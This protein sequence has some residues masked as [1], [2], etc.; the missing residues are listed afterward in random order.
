MAKILISDDLEEN[1]YLL[2]AL[3]QGHGHE[4]ISA[5]N[6]EEA[7]RMARQEMPDLIVTDILMPVMD[8]FTLCRE[9]KKDANLS[10]IPLI[11]YT[12]TYTDEENKGFGLGLGA[13]RYLIKPLEPDELIGIVNEVLEESDRAGERQA[14]KEIGNETSY[15]REYNE[16]L[17]RKLQARMAQLEVANGQLREQLSERRNAEMKLRRLYAAIQNAAECVAIGDDQGRIEYSNPAFEK[18]T[19]FSKDET[20]SLN[21][22]LMTSGIHDES[23]YRELWQAIS[24]EKSWTGHLTKKYGDGEKLELD[25]AISPIHDTSQD[26]GGFVLIMR[27][28]TV[29][30]RLR[31]QLLQSQKFEALG[32][33]AGGIAHDFNNMLS[34]IFGYTQLT[35][36]DA[37]AGSPIHSNL[38]AI[39]GVCDRAKSLVKQI[40]TFSRKMD[41]KMA[42]VDLCPMIKETMKFLAATLAPSTEFRTCLQPVHAFVLADPVQIHQVI[43]N[44]GTNAAYAMRDGGGVL[45]IVLKKIEVEE[46]TTPRHLNLSPGHYYLL[47]ISD[48]GCGMNKE[49]LS[50]IF[51]PFFTTKNEGE[52]TGLGLAMTYNIVQSHGGVICAYSEE[53]CGSIFNV[54]LPV[55]KASSVERDEADT[56][57]LPTGTERILFLDDEEE[58]ADIGEQILNRLG[59]QVVKTTSSLDALQLFRNAPSQFDLIITDQAMPRLTGVEL[60]EEVL[61]IRADLPILHS[62]ELR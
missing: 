57:P 53:G 54:Y 23:F 36:I 1:R 56:R 19:G 9:C 26:G 15:L 29:Q 41:Q 52:G 33:L 44:L 31:E 35:L 58:L 10:S 6:G 14:V 48:T 27:D 49:T 18:I 45:G 32:T 3:L 55:A 22:E 47:S 46:S 59:Y 61:K 5:V 24:S 4:I 2:Q 50:R 34:A 43:L 17:F 51:E 42:V 38:S 39:L 62:A 11:F 40:L 12:A 13:V 30:K 16:T 21:P 25:I 28:V 37:P 8:G 60:A 7:L 20:V